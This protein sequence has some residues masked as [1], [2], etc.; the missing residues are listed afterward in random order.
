MAMIANGSV[1][2]VLRVLGDPTRL[3]ILALL[4]QAELAVGELARA[5]GMSQ[6]RVSNH[7]KL[8][9]DADLLVERREGSFTYLKLHVPEG[10]PGELWRA[11]TPGL[12]ALDERKADNRRL[13][14]VLADRAD[15]RAFFDRIA[16]DWDLIGRDFARGTGRLEALSCL[17]PGELVVADVGCGT[18]FLARALARRAA[19]VICI[20]TSVAMLDKARENLRDVPAALEFRPGAMEAL[21]LQDG[22]VD[23]AF[24]HM[25]LHH[26]ADVPA[27]LREMARGVRAGGQVVCVELLPHHESW[28]HDL[29]ADARLGL[30]PGA[31]HND[32]RAAGLVDVEREMLDDAYVVEHPSGRKI[33]LPLFLMRGRR[34]AAPR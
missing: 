5:L 29:M 13:A 27:G 32:F 22:E 19:R 10:A 28:M 25:V 16:G 8:L 4:A 1:L 31:L 26:L 15:S 7:L 24:A 20:D 12:E 2:E 6:S 33:S 17:V 3:R 14:A 30:D 21:P 18:G 9:R 34:P 11:L 23:A